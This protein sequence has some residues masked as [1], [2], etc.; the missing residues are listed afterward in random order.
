[1][2]ANY[3]K[4]FI[5]MSKT[6][7]LVAYIIADF[8]LISGSKKSKPWRGSQHLTFKCLTRHSL[9]LTECTTYEK[10]YMVSNLYLKFSELQLVERDN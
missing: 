1:M 10:T 2:T 4:S 6:N 3:R 9:Q 7:F 5:G 8:A